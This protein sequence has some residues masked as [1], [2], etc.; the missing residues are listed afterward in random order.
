MTAKVK[1]SVLGLD[2]QLNEIVFAG[3]HDAGV[4]QGG[5]NTRTQDLN[6]LEQA[7]VGVRLFDLR[8]AAAATGLVG[9]SGHKIV[10][11]KAYHA[12]KSLVKNET[13]LRE[14]SGGQG[15]GGQARNIERTKLKGGGFGTSLPTMLTHAKD[16]VRKN[17]EEFLL[18]KF[19][20]CYNWSCIAQQ[21]VNILEDTI[22]SAPGNLNVKTLRQLRGRVIVL[23]SQ[24]GLQAARNDGWGVGDGIL[25]W[26]NI[27]KDG[28]AYST[29]FDGLQYFGAGGTSLGP[30]GDKIQENKNKQERLMRQGAG[31]NPDLIGMMYWTTTS[32]TGSIR[33][34]TQQQ[35]SLPNVAILQNMWANGLEESIMSRAPAITNPFEYSSAG[36]FRAFMPNFIMIDFADLDKCQAIYQLNSVASTALTSALKNY[37]AKQKAELFD[38]L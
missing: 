18:L 32:L 17:P 27:K 38:L 6:I 26:T 19:D 13:K 15:L 12:S 11:L 25:G 4:K 20:K 21:C 37:Q 7:N 10:E 30:G 28:G 1:Y 16:F 5:A 2:K 8:V 22:Y 36:F 31:R 24:E 35:W 14:V 33:A 34:R 23:F 3:S 29:N 9:T